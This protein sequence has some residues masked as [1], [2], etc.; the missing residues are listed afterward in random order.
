MKDYRS[1]KEI[2]VTIRETLKKEFPK[3]KFSVTVEH[4]NSIHVDLMA[5]PVEIIEAMHEW[6]KGRVELTPEQRARQYVQLN[7]YQ[8]LSPLD[9]EKRLTNG[10]YLTP[11]GWKVL[12]RAA[13][14]LSKEHWDESEPQIDYFCCNYYRNLAIGKWDRPYVVR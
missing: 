11:T 10:V 3:W 1:P 8:V 7:H 6:D 5:G 2:A 12:K 4:Y 9:Q 13:E 14:I